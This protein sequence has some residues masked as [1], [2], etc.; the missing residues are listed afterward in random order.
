MA[1]YRF[2]GALN[3]AQFPL[4][5]VLQGRTV[6]QPQLD[7]NVRTV[8]A[9][10]GTEESADYSIP[11]LLYCENVMPTAEGIQSVGYLQ[12]INPHPSA[13][14]FDQAI[15]IRDEDENNFIFVP[16]GGNNYFYD[17]VT[18][19]WISVDPIVATDLRVTR[20][21]VNGRTFICYDGLGLFEYNAGLG[22]FASVPLTGIAAADIRGISASNN[23]LLAFGDLTVYWSSL[24]DPTDF[25]PS[26]ITGAGFSIPQDV[27]A[28]ITNIVGAAGG[29]VIYTVKNAVSA[30]YTQNIRAPF[31][32]KEIGNAGGVSTYE[33]V[34]SDQSSG[35][36]YIWGTGGLQKITMQGSEPVSAE[37]S[38]F[39]AGRIWEYW[40]PSS[41][42]LIQVNAEDIE[43]RVK[44]A[45]I[46]SRFLV[47]SYSV[48]STPTFQYALIYDTSLKRWG[49]VKIDHVD[50]FPYPYYAFLGDPTYDELGEISYDGLGSA[51]YDGLGFDTSTDPPSKRTVAFLQADGT[52]KLL[53]MDYNK[54]E[55][56]AGVAIFGKF[57]LLR[58]RMLTLQTLDLEGAYTT[59]T[60]GVPRVT[61][62]AMPSL[63][64]KNLDSTVSMKLLLSKHLLQRYG[65]RVAGLNVSVA[66]EGTF[67]LSSYILEVTADG[68]R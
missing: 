67:A 4:V 41:K 12:V 7:N 13:T 29:F 23:Y 28:K 62:T 30:V 56:Q 68:D 35:P 54:E 59:N 53:L 18:S 49:K 39:L 2:R 3:A 25:T 26:L 32:F 64:G 20:A 50:C 21:Y 58:A 44:L 51:S 14:D 19:S 34:T 46:S 15:I 8:Q 27:K 65:R 11:Q 37:A 31:A 63:D 47:I 52:V 9:F 38:D 60:D 66:I 6:V 24:I 36:Q 55:S 33:Q 22:T 1:K 43:F 57:Q 17:S 16:A 5:S 40:D 42:Q 45:Y 48:D 10:Y 61:V